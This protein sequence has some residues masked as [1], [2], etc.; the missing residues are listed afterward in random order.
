MEVRLIQKG[1]RGLFI[2]NGSKLLFPDRSWKDAKEGFAY[3]V[4]ITLDKGTYAF[5]RGKMLQT[6][7]IGVEDLMDSESIGSQYRSGTINGQDFLIEWRSGSSEFHGY[8]VF[9]RTEK[10]GNVSLE[11]L[12]MVGKRDTSIN[13]L[14]EYSKP[15]DMT[16]VLTKSSQV[17]NFDGDEEYAFEMFKLLNA[18]YERDS[19]AGKVKVKIRVY[20]S[21][22]AIVRHSYTYSRD[23]YEVYR[24]IGEI[25]SGKFEMVPS[26]FSGVAEKLWEMGDD[27]DL[28]ELTDF[29]MEYKVSVAYN[30][31]NDRTFDE[32][33]NGRVFE[34]SGSGIVVYAFNMQG[35]D[36]SWFE[37]EEAQPYI[38]LVEESF[39][40]LAYLKSRLAKTGVGIDKLSSLNVRGWLMPFEE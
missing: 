33:L 12:I 6:T 21:S 17:L 36:K 7:P 31:V 26:L 14:A 20:N 28:R 38:A 2:S 30:R 32:R 15:I 35:Y 37:T 16:E 40:R 23:T 39:A 9:L 27:L 22:L 4:E 3:D 19:F 25:G 18:I 10:D 5:V 34:C 13:F 8:R 11:R 24:Y 1:D 29:A